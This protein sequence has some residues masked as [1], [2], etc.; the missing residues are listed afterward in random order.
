MEGQIKQENKSVR[1]VVVG[2][3]VVIVVI[4]ALLLY[5]WAPENGINGDATD[6][7]AVPVEGSAVTD[8]EITAVV[9]Q[10][11]DNRDAS[12]CEKIENGD[13]KEYCLSNVII[14]QASDARDPLICNELKDE[15]SRIA[16]RDNIIFA[17]ARDAQDPSLCDT[18]TDKTRVSQCQE[19]AQ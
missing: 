4:G 2:I 15:Y 12:L 3:V 5:G 9:R 18:L 7:S 14:T 17:K 11:I 8:E 16:C 1:G 6:A 13:A 19:V 10:A